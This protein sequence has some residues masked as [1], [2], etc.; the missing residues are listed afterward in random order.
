MAEIG[1]NPRLFGV[2]ITFR[3]PEQ[4]AATLRAVTAQTRALDGLVV[5]DNAASPETREILHAIVPDAEYVAAPE[6]LGPAGGIALGMEHV[7]PRADD[8]DWIV[9]LDD[10]DPPRDDE[11]FAALFDFAAVASARDPAT[12]AVGVEG[13]WFDRRRGRIR[14]VPDSALSD[15]VSV[16]FIGGDFCPCY[17]VRAIRSVGTPRR[18]LFFGF[19]DLEYGL[20]LRAAGYALQVSGRS[21][22]ASREANGTLGQDLV[23]SR[24]LGRLS[25]RRYYS[26][27]N[28][29]RILRDSGSIGAALR[30]T[31]IVGLAKPLANVFVDPTLAF[32]HLRLNVRA[33]LDAW[34]GRMGR[35]VEPTP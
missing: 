7:L 22:L 1:R 2:L 20:R 16:D 33:C 11:V 26:L 3:R 24:G 10:D 35:T 17:S 19:D 27:R 18:D 32:G 25:W 9:T 28:L 13:Q 4:L 5:V 21:F 8:D 23:P 30:V 29:V 14:W 6:N 15:D 12:A 31:V 34:T